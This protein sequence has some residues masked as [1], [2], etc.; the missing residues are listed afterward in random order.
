MLLTAESGLRTAARPKPVT[1]GEVLE[2]SEGM[3]AAAQKS[4]S[5]VFLG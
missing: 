1:H 4:W 2:R 3:L 5:A